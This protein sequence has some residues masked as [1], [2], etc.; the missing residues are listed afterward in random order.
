MFVD[1]I[2]RQTFENA[3]QIPRENN[4]QNVIAL[5]HDTDQNYA[6]TPQSIKKISTV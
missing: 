2:T 3:N 1:P 6:L 5:D 4:L